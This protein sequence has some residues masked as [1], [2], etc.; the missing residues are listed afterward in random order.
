MSREYKRRNKQKIDAFLVL[1]LLIVYLK[2]IHKGYILLYVL[3]AV[4]LI[5]AVKL[6]AKWRTYIRINNP[7]LKHIDGMTGLEFEKCVANMLRNQDFKHVKITERYDYG[8]DI[9]AEKDGVR[10]GI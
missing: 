3:L 7:K 1:V 4:A 5:L 2:I 10:W 8:V 9:I 6:F